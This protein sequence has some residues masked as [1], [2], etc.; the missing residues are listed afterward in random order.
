MKEDLI[1]R[2]EGLYWTLY[3]GEESLGC[4]YLEDIAD[5]LKEVT[6]RL[7]NGEKAEEIV[8]EFNDFR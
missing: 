3:L 1:L 2:K 8:E 4:G 7:D 6:K 5:I